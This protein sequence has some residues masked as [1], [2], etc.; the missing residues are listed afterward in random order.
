[1]TREEGEELNRALATT[2][3]G[4]S[5]EAPNQVASG[6]PINY[7]ATVVNLGR[8]PSSSTI[9]RASLEGAAWSSQ[10]SSCRQTAAGLECELGELE[11]RE[12]RTVELKAVSGAAG[13]TVELTL[14]VAN[15][16]GPDP[17]EGNNTAVARTVAGV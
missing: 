17:N 3:L 1:M 14:T 8:N 7:R 10:G 16:L 12:S 9:L 6:A 2:D 5:V 11:A 4:V 13:G 15:R